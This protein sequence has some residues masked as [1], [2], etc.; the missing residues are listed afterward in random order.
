MRLNVFVDKSQRGTKCRKVNKSAM[1]SR[2]VKDMN[3]HYEK[4]RISGWSLEVFIDTPIKKHRV[5][6][7]RVVEAGRITL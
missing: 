3:R 5:K 2:C 6:S 4:S 7:L 1:F